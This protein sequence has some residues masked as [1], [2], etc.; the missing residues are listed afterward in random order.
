M[1]TTVLYAGISLN[2]KSDFIVGHKPGRER[3]G[4]M[5]CRDERTIHRIVRKNRF[6]TQIAYMK[7]LSEFNVN[8][9][10]TTLQRR[11]KELEYV[12]KVPKSKPL[13]N[14]VQRK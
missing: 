6:I 8:I 5:N 4:I 2:T 11:M 9:R 1:D 10:L 13:L 12:I 3:K 14:I 7:Y